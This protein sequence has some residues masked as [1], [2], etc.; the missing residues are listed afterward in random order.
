M[1]KLPLSKLLGI[2]LIAGGAV[3]GVILMVLMSGYAASGQLSS[4]TATLLVMAALLLFVLPQIALGVYL[5][6]HGMGKTAVSPPTQ[7][8]PTE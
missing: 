1:T 5:I 3:V 7:N 6:W 2:A 4:T 8:P